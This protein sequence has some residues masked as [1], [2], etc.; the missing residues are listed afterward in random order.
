MMMTTMMS[1]TQKH[2]C[3]KRERESKKKQNMCS[4][5]NIYILQVALAGFF[6]CI[7]PVIV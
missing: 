2:D 7:L 1:F 6:F 5:L 4:G 3:G